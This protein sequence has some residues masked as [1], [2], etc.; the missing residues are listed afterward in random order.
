MKYNL[1]HNLVCIICPNG[2]PSQLLTSLN[3]TFLLES[4]R[5]FLNTSTTKHTFPISLP[6]LLHGV[7]GSHSLF[8]R[9]PTY[10][11]PWTGSHQNCCYV[12]VLFYGIILDSKS[13]SVLFIDLVQHSTRKGIL[14]HATI[15]GC[16]LYHW[17]TCTWAGLATKVIQKHQPSVLVVESI[18]VG[19][20]LSFIVCTCT[21]HKQVL[22]PNAIEAFLM[23]VAFSKQ[24]CVV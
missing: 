21:V 9:W 2:V 15:A 16:V 1:L 17:C 11:Q 22:P 18:L 10:P 6:F 14:L 4:L 12:H 20:D 13:G 7:P 5:L 8:I 23:L 24:L 3:L 19:C